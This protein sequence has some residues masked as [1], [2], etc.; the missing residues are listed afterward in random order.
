MGRAYTGCAYIGDHTLEW[1]FLYFCKIFF[2]KMGLFFTS[3]EIV[4][5][6]WPRPIQFSLGY[7]CA[8]TNEKM[9]AFWKSLDHVM[10]LSRD[11]VRRIEVERPIKL[12]RL[13]W[14]KGY[15]TNWPK[16]YTR[17]WRTEY[18]PEWRN[19]W[20]LSHVTQSCD[21]VYHVKPS[22]GYGI[23]E[24]SSVDSQESKNLKVLL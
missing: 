4:L 10:F 5:I 6:K 2:M 20:Y 22:Q 21:K 13:F 24:V 23:V 17:V 18:V 7:E 14:L 15:F 8:K 16:V 12:S 9:R 19:T 3:L 1:N 11:H